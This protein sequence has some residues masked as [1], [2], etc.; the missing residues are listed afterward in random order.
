MNRANQSG[1]VTS[2]RWIDLPAAIIQKAGRQIAIRIEHAYG[3]HR[4]R[5][6]IFLSPRFT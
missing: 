3:R 2:P 5:A 4:F 1:V 6:D